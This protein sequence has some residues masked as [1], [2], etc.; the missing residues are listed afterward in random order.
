LALVLGVGCGGT[1]SDRREEVAKR[2]A[3]VMPF[4][5]DKTTHRFTPTA[6]GLVET[7]V[8]D[9]PGD[10]QQV[11]LIRQHL[12]H[13]AS[14]F[15]TGDYADPAHIH[16]HNMPGLAD[17]QAHP[18]RVTVTFTERPDG[19]RLTFTSDTPDLV[20]ALHRWGAAQTRDH[21]GRAEG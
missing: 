5:L 14:R 21:G 13:E 10:D 2:G 15:R 3:E 17:L 16:G 4:D 9:D 19:A 8:A 18:D 7:V 6:T 11:A 12:T 20:T 1:A